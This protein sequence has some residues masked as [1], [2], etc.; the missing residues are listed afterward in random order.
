MDRLRNVYSTSHLLHYLPAINGESSS[1]RP[2][3]VRQSTVRQ[4]AHS[5]PR[6]RRCRE[7]SERLQSAC[8]QEF[9]RQLAVSCQEDC[10]RSMLRASMSSARIA[11]R[12]SPSDESIARIKRVTFDGRRLDIR[13]AQNVASGKMS[14]GIF[15]SS[16]RLLSLRLR[17][18]WLQFV[19]P[20]PLRPLGRPWRDLW[21]PSSPTSAPPPCGSPIPRPLQWFPA[22]RMSRL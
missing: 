20:T 15:R 10:R 4:E 7:A 3:N 8:L 17:G 13:R 1:R 9:S 18:M 16:P 12:F 14:I 21:M 5:R 11:G 22:Y 2:T 19:Q 6:L